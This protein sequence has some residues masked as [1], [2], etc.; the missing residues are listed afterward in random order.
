MKKLLLVVALALASACAS[1]PVNKQPVPFTTLARG[2]YCEVTRPAAHVIRNHAELETFWDML[3][4][5]KQKVPDI[6][7]N[8]RTILAIFMGE[9]AS[10][11]Y[12][13]R[14]DRIVQTPE[15]VIVEVRKTTPAKGSAV[16]MA[17][18]RPYILVSIPRT[19]LPIEF[20]YQTE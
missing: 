4:P 13:I 15:E 14:I 7:F 2:S 9:Q 1:P 8:A 3:G 12:A 11:G 5:D 6:D 17:L 10:G 20:Q 19:E 18:T 16:S